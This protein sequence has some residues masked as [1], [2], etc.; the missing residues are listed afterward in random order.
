[1]GSGFKFK[2]G[3][4]NLKWYENNLKQG[5]NNFWGVVLNLKWEK[6]I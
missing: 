1:L 2:T 6:I 3:E 5:K 4:N